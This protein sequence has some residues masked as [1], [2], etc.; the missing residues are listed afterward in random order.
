MPVK[1]VPIE[2]PLSGGIDTKTD[3]KLV[4]LPN[5]L[6]LKDV[7]HS[8]TGS[9]KG[10]PGYTAMSNNIVGGTTLSSL[11]K[12][13][14][15]GTELV[16]I[17]DSFYSYSAAHE[18][19]TSKGTYH[20]YK[21]T[22]KEG[23]TVYSTQ[24][25]I[26]FATD[27]N[28]LVYAWEDS[29]GGA[30]YSIE[31]AATG[32]VL[33]TPTQLSATGT[34]CQVVNTSAGCVIGWVDT[35]TSSIDLLGVNIANL[36][37]TKTQ[38]QL[39]DFHSDY[40][41]DMA[42]D[43][44][45]DYNGTPPG[46]I[47][48]A[49]KTTVNSGADFRAVYLDAAGAVHP[50]VAPVYSTAWTTTFYGL[51]EI[52]NYIS[53]NCVI[54]D[55]HT[56]ADARTAIVWATATSTE[57]LW[58]EDDG[59][60]G[61]GRAIVASTSS[62]GIGMMMQN[63]NDQQFLVQDSNGVVTRYTDTN[64]SGTPTSQGT[65]SNLPLAGKPFFTEDLDTVTSAN[66]TNWFVPVSYSSNLQS[67][68]FI[69]DSSSKV[70]ASLS[71][72][73]AGIPTV[74]GPLMQPVYDSSANTVT[75]ATG[76]KQRLSI[77][78]DQEDAYSADSVRLYTLDVS[79]TNHYDTVEANKSLYIGGSQV[80]QYDGDNLVE[81]GFHLFPEVDR[82]A[83]GFTASGA[84]LDYNV[85]NQPLTIDRTDGGAG[86]LTLIYYV[87]Y[88]WYDAQGKRHQSSAIPITCTNFTDPGT[89]NVSIVVPG[90]PSEL[91]LK[92]NVRGVVYRTHNDSI[93]LAY[94]LGETDASSDNTYTDDTPEASLKSGEL[95]Y[96]SAGE[97]DNVAPGAATRLF[98]HDD[99]VFYISDRDQTQ[100]F[101]SKRPQTG[102]G[103]GFN[104][105]LVISMPDDI[106]AVNVLDNKICLFERDKL[107]MVSGDGPN[108]LGIGAYSLPRLVST[109][110]G[111]KDSRSLVRVPQGLMFQSDKG[112]YWLNRGEAINYVGAPVEAYNS[113][114]IEDATVIP[115]DRRAIFL[116]QDA[117]TL[118]FDYD[119]NLWTTFTNHAGLSSVVINDSYYYLRST[120]DA[121]WL[122]DSTVFSDAG[123]EI[124][125]TA[126][127]PWIHP[128]G[129]Q[130]FWH[131][132][133]WQLLGN[134]LSTHDLTI[135]VFF[136][137]DDDYLAYETTW[138]PE[139][140]LNVGTLGGNAT[141]GGGYALGINTE[142]QNDRVYQV[143]QFFKYMR[144]QSVSLEIRGVAPGTSPGSMFEL[145]S[146]LIMGASYGD[147]FKLP[148]S[149]EI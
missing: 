61:N 141:L 131:A 73:L 120:G 4:Q 19:W 85:A 69:L 121:V 40:L 105:G 72:G 12:I 10:R 75:L 62:Y 46:A 90:L 106:T 98:F 39:A 84:T 109:D 103:V 122:G 57:V 78:D 7:I 25:D 108:N 124:V 147:N 47:V 140:A 43:V 104:D 114:T 36:S 77:D 65:Y 91:T 74:G 48:L 139:S 15:R 144:V 113:Y 102:D 79:K 128:L 134:Y 66:T 83:N 5:F 27:G 68:I 34:K 135:R 41:W 33:K 2:L 119:R 111:C 8:K 55:S 50:T 82:S 136:N 35:T 116:T 89:D 115:D 63:L 107:F 56:G 112:I 64:Y 118:V 53:V 132:Y 95:L 127:L 110:T 17:G 70:V 137:Y 20:H 59:E 92:S 130:Q 38:L 31:D 76:E 6:D 30:Y 24:S 97:L 37:G 80:W 117:R 22:S 14:K 32:A 93:A 133:K 44:N 148:G 13:A 60:L 142:G 45:V 52:V 54:P 9:L 100:V 123:N 67:T 81:A 28:I 96:L 3:R 138:N 29:R 149:K 94:R 16:A 129:I 11:K 26:T 23:P 18:E 145:T 99:R 101:Y 146:L 49:Y 42:W 126:R 88:E 143:G 51:T 86:V 87:L 71:P 1:P 125:P 58:S 21:L